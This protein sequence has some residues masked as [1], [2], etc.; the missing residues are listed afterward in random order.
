[1]VMQNITAGKCD[2]SKHRERERERERSRHK[3]IRAGLPPTPLSSFSLE[4][5]SRIYSQA[6]VTPMTLTVKINITSCLTNIY[7][8]YISS[9]LE[10]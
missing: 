6:S 5:P 2:G 1:M 8:S 10:D 3:Y 9:L 7:V 4:T